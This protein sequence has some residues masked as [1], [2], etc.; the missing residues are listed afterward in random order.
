VPPSID[1]SASAR[2]IDLDTNADANDWMNTVS[3][4]AHVPMPGMTASDG[5]AVQADELVA[6]PRKAGNT[7]IV[8][9]HADTDQHLPFRPS[10]WNV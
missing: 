7:H 6:A 9:G 4:L 10:R 2:G 8:I 3:G 5:I 1:A